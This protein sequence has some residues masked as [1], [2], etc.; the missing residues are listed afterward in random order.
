MRGGELQQWHA[1]SAYPLQL[2]QLAMKQATRKLESSSQ[3]HDILH[4]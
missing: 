2:L 4:F 1:K 3:Q